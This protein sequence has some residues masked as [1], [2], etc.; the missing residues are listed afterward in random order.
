MNYNSATVSSNT[1]CT[2][3]QHLI[4]KLR[5]FVE[6]EKSNNRLLQSINTLCNQ[7]FS[8][9]FNEL[10][11]WFQAQSK[12]DLLQKCII[13]YIIYQKFLIPVYYEIKGY[14]LV[15]FIRHTIIRNFLLKNLFGKI[16]LKNK[17][18]SEKINQE[19]NKVKKDLRKSLIKTTPELTNYNKL[20]A[21]GLTQGEIVEYL[22]KSIKLLPHSDYE[23]GKVSG[24]VYHGGKELIDI[25][26]ISFQKY[27]V[28]NQLHPDVFP[29]L[30]NM[31]AEVV[32]MVL[33]MFHADYS[34][35]FVGSTTSGGTESLLL[36]CL[37]AKMYGLKYKN[38][39]E[40]EIIIPKTAHAGFY[41]AGYYFNIKIRE[42]NID[43][44]TYKVDLKH[45]ANLI[46]KN[47]CLLVGSAPNFPHGIIDDIEGLSEL[48]LRNNGGIPLHVDCC[49]GSFIVAYM[50]KCGFSVG[51]GY[52]DFRVPG[53]TSISCDTHKYGFAPKGSSVLMYRNATLRSC[54]YYISTDWC[55]GLYG[56]PTLA[57]SRPGALVVGCWS[58]MVHM[59]SKGYLE[60]C[61]EIVGAAMALK[62]FIQQEIPALKIN[63]DP[64]CSVVSFAFQDENKYDIYELSD[65]LSKNE[66]WHMNTLQNPAA[67]HFAL[68]RLSAPIVETELCPILKRTVEE[69]VKEVDSRNDDSVDK[70]HGANSD[71]SA[72]YGVAGSVKTTGIADRLVEAFLDTLFQPASTDI[73]D[74]NVTSTTIETDDIIN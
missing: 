8:Q 54:Q 50:E 46:N 43:P 12:W 70:K 60:S 47:T 72:L 33:Q 44:V 57:G 62:K 24:A 4:D 22:D 29:G 40:P 11:D 53:V 20:P 36:A 67:I 13:L 74:V 69:Y 61:K 71:T 39:T 7:P 64:L 31:E 41:K 27:C 52:F 3:E 55:G 51:P 48:A 26:T 56:S 17:L 18:A 66:H 15:Y 14:G 65:R 32:S 58:T 63:G 10:F 1:S 68:T 28:G 45:V 59:G 38:I 21:V 2:M 34:K 16:I 25:Q 49:L 19:V 9:I 37:S 42:A 73:P 5:L 23:H 6:N 30:R 35:G